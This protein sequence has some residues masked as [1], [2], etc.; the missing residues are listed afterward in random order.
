MILAR[1][2]ELRSPTGG[3]LVTWL[4]AEH[5]ICGRSVT[6]KLP[7]GGKSPPMLVETVH[8]LTLSLQ[9]VQEHARDWTKSTDYVRGRNR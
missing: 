4:P 2:C 9:Q 1:Q 8:E 7:E 5:A 3:R 6:L